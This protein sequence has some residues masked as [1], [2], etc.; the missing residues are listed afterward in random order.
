M[1]GLDR[2]YRAQ[3]KKA[4]GQSEFTTKVAERIGQNSEHARKF[5]SELKN[6]FGDDGEDRLVWRTPEDNE[7]F[8][9]YSKWRDL[10]HNRHEK[11][12]RPDWLPSGKFEYKRANFC[13]F[14]TRVYADLMLGGGAE[15][16]T[17]NQTVDDYL[18]DEVQL[19][20]YFY[21]WAQLVTVYGLIG[22]QVVCD[23][24]GVDIIKVNPDLLYP[25]FEDGSDDDFKWVSKKHYVDPGQIKPEPGS[26]WEFNKHKD[27]GEK[28]DGVVFEERHF[29]GYIEYYLFTVKG[30]EITEM[31]PPTWYND[32]L[33]DLNGD[34]I[35][36]VDTNIDEFMLIVVPNIIFDGT[37][38]SDF[39]DIEDFQRDINTRASQINRIL[40]VHADPKLMLPDSFR[41][42]DPYTGE[43]IVRGLRDEVL[44]LTPEDYDFKPEYLT[45]QSQLEGA[46]QE[47]ENDMNMLCTVAS[48]SPSLVVRKDGNFPEAAATYKLRLTPTL[49]HVARKEEDFKRALQRVIWVFI[50]KCHQE[51]VFDKSE[52][53]FGEEQGSP[54]NKPWVAQGSPTGGVKDI[55]FDKHDRLSDLDRVLTIPPNKIEIRFKP[56][57]PQD[58]RFLV[59]RAGSMPPTASIHRVLQEVDGMNEAEIAIELKRIAEGQQMAEEA[60]A[61]DS[62]LQF[63]GNPFE[64][65]SETSDSGLD[66][67]PTGAQVAGLDAAIA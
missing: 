61:R 3:L 20:G 15:I 19:H 52:V 58:E 16:S 57:L 51:R 45:W 64:G 25:V 46:Y 50:N 34:G 47:M 8:E 22:L 49:N 2:I 18:S 65:R 38:V 29:R 4:L 5:A 63:G 31:L 53:D 9:A 6:G 13:R 26:N 12:L 59:E 55:S 33:P 60:T 1:A 7:R 32:N 28:D 30:D 10:F 27:G 23:D 67:S 48:V 44:I 56:S 39:A 62:G 40:N 36:K 43:A 41:A 66:A 35:C 11:W 21:K 24:K 17:G 14:I 54:G 37:F 42:K